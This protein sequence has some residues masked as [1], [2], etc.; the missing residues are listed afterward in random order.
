[1][2][3]TFKNH[4]NT[5]YKIDGKEIWHARYIAIEAIIL[6]LYNN[7]IYV[8]IEKRSST[9]PDCPNMWAIP[10]GYLDFD[11]NGWDAIT[12]EIY[13]ETSLY[14]PEYED[15]LITNNNKKPFEVI[16]EPDHYKQNVV[17]TY[18]C[19]FNFGTLNNFFPIEILDYKNKE[20]AEIKWMFLE[21]VLKLQLAFNHN[22]HLKNAVEVFQ[23]H[24]I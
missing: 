10:S 16:T 9:M 11:E 8:L 7:N 19:I 13:E 23:E 17:L 22:D 24:L 2:N 14:L 12:R 4:P 6:A 15:Y 3:P 18:C 20:V 5:S 1:V 21:E